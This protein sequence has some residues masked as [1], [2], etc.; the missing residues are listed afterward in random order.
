MP[1][2]YPFGGGE[3]VV[4]KL[5]EA[6]LQR[7]RLLDACRARSPSPVTM[8]AAKTA[9][10]YTLGGAC[11]YGTLGLMSHATLDVPR[12]PPVCRSSPPGAY[13]ARSKTAE[14]AMRTHRR[15]NILRHK[16]VGSCTVA[17]PKSQSFVLF[18]RQRV[19]DLAVC[20]LCKP[21]LGLDN[22]GLLLSIEQ[23]K[24]G[25]DYINFCEVHS[26]CSS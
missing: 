24:A 26:N 3:T 22:N 14:T 10:D 12:G 16:C 21:G 4:N 19:Q 15:W 20:G 18:L 25:C 17:D 8:V 7:S 1:G 5:R 11:A 6:R 13:L 23:R 2:S 9:L